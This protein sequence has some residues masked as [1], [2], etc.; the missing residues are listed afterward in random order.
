MLV[1]LEPRTGTHHL[2]QPV[3]GWEVGVLVVK[4]GEDHIIS[5]SLL[6]EVVLDVLDGP[7][8]RPRQESDQC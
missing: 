3:C 7:E 5:A 8:G 4:D 6:D 1:G 2:A